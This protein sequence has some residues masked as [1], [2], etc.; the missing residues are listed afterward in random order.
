MD[1]VRFGEETKV[2]LKEKVKVESD[3]KA[4]F[5]AIVANNQDSFNANMI[6]EMRKCVQTAQ[7]NYGVSMAEE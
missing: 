2:M 6:A 4:K 1:A 5:E 3:Q 7:N